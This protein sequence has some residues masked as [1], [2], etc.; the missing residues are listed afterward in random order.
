MEGG[1]KL[2]TI[3]TLLSTKMVSYVAVRKVREKVKV[4]VSQIIGVF[5]K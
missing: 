5:L 3:C 1:R 2:E 4:N